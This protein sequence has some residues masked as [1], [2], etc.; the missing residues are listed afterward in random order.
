MEDITIRKITFWV[1]EEGVRK[2]WV[3]TAPIEVP[4]CW[5]DMT[6]DDQHKYLAK[7]VHTISRLGYTLHN[8]SYF[9][10]EAGIFDNVTDF[11]FETSFP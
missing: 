5:D 4:G 9:Q 3:A 10:F 6:K 7:P 1:K 8:V 11:D 2:R